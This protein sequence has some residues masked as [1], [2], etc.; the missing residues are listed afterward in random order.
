MLI[1]ILVLKY[2]FELH[3]GVQILL[4]RVQLKR[5]VKKLDTFQ[6]NCDVAHRCLPLCA[7]RG[8]NIIEM[9]FV[10]VSKENH[11][12]KVLDMCGHVFIAPSRYRAALQNTSVRSDH[13]F[14]FS[15]FRHSIQG[16]SQLI[17]YYFVKQISIAGVVCLSMMRFPYDRLWEAE[18]GYRAKI[19]AITI[20]AIFGWHIVAK[21]CT[22]FALHYYL[23][24]TL[25]FG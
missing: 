18:A 25:S 21:V 3:L 14:E 24:L 15:S 10:H 23:Y 8:A 20:P 1:F 5:R 2:I 19:D 11:T 12:V 7:L 13:R 17:A 9:M 16:L 22:V 6:V 4:I